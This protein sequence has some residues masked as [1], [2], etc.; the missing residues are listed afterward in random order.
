ME[1]QLA[2]ALSLEERFRVPRLAARLIE[3]DPEATEKGKS[4]Q[5]AM[6]A[7]RDETIGALGLFESLRH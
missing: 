1:A 3:K 7:Q 2:G 4:D 6:A 5:W